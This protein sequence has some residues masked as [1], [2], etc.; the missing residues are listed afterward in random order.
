MLVT[1][2]QEGRVISC[3]LRLLPEVDEHSIAVGGDYENALLVT[4]ATLTAKHG[5][6]PHNASFLIPSPLI[7]RPDCI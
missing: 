4:P 7:H 2:Q 5:L 3:D 6:Q 1:V